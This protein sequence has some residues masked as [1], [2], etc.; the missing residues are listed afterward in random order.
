MNIIISFWDDSSHLEI[1][2]F[3]DINISLKQGPLIILPKYKS[4]YDIYVNWLAL[5]WL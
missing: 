2:C 5:T 4:I 3:R 1:N